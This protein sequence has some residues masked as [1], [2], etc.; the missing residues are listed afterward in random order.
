M[1]IVNHEITA[2]DGST[3]LWVLGKNGLVLEGELDAAKLGT[4]KRR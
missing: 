3:K 2:R 1:S 4:S